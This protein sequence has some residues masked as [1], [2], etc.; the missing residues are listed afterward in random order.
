[1]DE[2]VPE[3]LDL[4]SA[5]RRVKSNIYH[6]LVIGPVIDTWVTGCRVVT[7]EGTDIESDFQLFYSDWVFS[8]IGVRSDIDK[9]IANGARFDCKETNHGI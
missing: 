4:V 8:K 7:N 9:M 1:M 3:I 6:N 2:Y 5:R